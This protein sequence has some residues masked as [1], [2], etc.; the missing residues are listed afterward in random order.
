MRDRQP[1]RPV[2]EPK[3]PSATRRPGATR[4]ADRPRSGW[5]PSPP[6]SLRPVRPAF[7]DGEP[8]RVPK[9]P[10]RVQLAHPYPPR[11][12]GEVPCCVSVSIAVCMEIL[13]AR[14]G[15][16]K[17]APL[18]HYFIA[19]GGG[20]AL[21]EIDFTTG[22]NA[23]GEHGVCRDGLH[24]APFTAA[25]ARQGPSPAAERD[26]PRQRLVLSDEEGGADLW[27]RL[28]PD[29]LEDWRAALAKGYPIVLGFRTTA[30]YWR[31]KGG[32]AVHPPID[33]GDDGGAA[34][35]GHAVAVVGY[36]DQKHGGS[37]LIKD[38]RGDRFGSGGSW[39]LPYEIL[40]YGPFEEAYA[41]TRVQFG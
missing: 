28:H 37:L 14:R 18:F 22:L 35:D 23:A 20:E 13:G 15:A 5:R 34:G 29:G 39:Y 33:G 17:L 31:L 38:S 12:Q 21:D 19:R 1:R 10:P 26:G 6:R 27:P 8:G 7:L 16:R 32:L 11:A 41:L 3:P 4:D 30:A 40:S 9:L 25:G 36:D 2:N 24:G